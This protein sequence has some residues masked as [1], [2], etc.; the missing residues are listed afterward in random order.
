MWNMFIT[1]IKFTKFKHIENKKFKV[2][3]KIL[4]WSIPRSK[5]K[6]VKS[7]NTNGKYAIPKNEQDIHD[8]F[9]FF[10][11]VEKNFDHSFSS[12]TSFTINTRHSR[13]VIDVLR[14]INI[15]LKFNTKLKFVGIFFL[16]WNSSK[17]CLLN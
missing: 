5:K 14:N 7:T 8:D 9:A 1:K 16:L 4:M 3:M 10:L 2:N 11:W 6:F 12:M 17:F 15:E 13:V